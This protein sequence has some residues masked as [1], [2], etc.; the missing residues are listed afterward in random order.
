MFHTALPVILS[1]HIACYGVCAAAE[2]FCYS[3]SYHDHKNQRSFRNNC[4]NYRI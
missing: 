3:A 4:Q 2:E 1:S